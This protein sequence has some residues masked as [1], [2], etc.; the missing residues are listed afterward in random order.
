MKI[1]YFLFGAESSNLANLPNLRRMRHTLNANS[2]IY[3]QKAIF[4]T[5]LCI[6]FLADERFNVRFLFCG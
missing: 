4:R 3:V 5:L 2:G 1:N 6:S